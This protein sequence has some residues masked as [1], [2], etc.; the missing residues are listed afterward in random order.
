MLGDS[1]KLSLSLSP[2]ELTSKPRGNVGG[3][4]EDLLHYLRRRERCEVSTVTVRTGRRQ[5]QG[6]FP[7]ALPIC[8]PGLRSH[9]IN[10]AIVGGPHGISAG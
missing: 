4:R 6:A 2:K 1:R 5:R 9:G 10:V 8:I 7:W 3:R